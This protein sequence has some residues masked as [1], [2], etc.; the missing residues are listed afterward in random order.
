[1]KA[2]LKED[3]IGEEI[4]KLYKEFGPVRTIKFFKLLG[5]SKGDTL[6]EI[7][8]QT[9]R[10]SKKEAIRLVKRVK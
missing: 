1:M 3:L 4:R 7:E 10:L 5:I 6:R 2:E 9:A 8:E